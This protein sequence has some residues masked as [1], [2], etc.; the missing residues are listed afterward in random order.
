MY[1]TFGV[2]A[3]EIASGSKSANPTDEE[4]EKGLVEWVLDLYG[5]GNLVS[6]VDERLRMKFDQKQIDCLMIMWDCCV[7]TLIKI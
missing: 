6:G 7:L 3:L 4:T 2:V 1:S 5:K